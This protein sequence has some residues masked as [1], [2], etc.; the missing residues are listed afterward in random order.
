MSILKSLKKTSVI[1]VG[2]IA[3]V[4]LTSCGTT[5]AVQGSSSGKVQTIQVGVQNAYKPFD[6][7]NEDGELDGYEVHV[8]KALDEA[9]PQYQ[10]NLKPIDWQNA[11]VS[12][13]TGKVD[14][15]VNVY[16][17][18]KAR[19]AKYD[20]TKP[21]LYIP[22]YISVSKDNNE[23][24][25]LDN[26]GNAKVSYYP[27]TD[28]GLF[29]ENYNK[30]NSTSKLNLVNVGGYSAEQLK[31]GFKAGLYDVGLADKPSH[32]TSNVDTGSKLVGTPV[33]TAPTGFL[34]SKGKYTKL[35]DDINNELEKL[36][37]DGTLKKISEQYLKG[38]YSS[39]IPDVPE[40]AY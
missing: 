25:N 18:T 37:A 31:E 29:L 40:F 35:R 14:F 3:V 5:N 13:D 9:L 2:L 28:S 10:F 4:G 20:Y 12:L 24:T 11:I 19:K 30:E 27:G 6:Y 32:D 34:F 23:I 15:S 8:L 39:P 38:D 21:D 16:T 33:Y 26:I 17:L 7:L 22:Y 1:L 36:R